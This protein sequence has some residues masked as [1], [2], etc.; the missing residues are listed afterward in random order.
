MTDYPFRTAIIETIR[1]RGISKRLLCRRARITES[2]LYRFLL[3]DKDLLGRNL[4]NLRRALGLIITDPV[5]D[6]D[7]MDDITL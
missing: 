1:R 7:E 2:Q 5:P 6:D 3:H 4:D